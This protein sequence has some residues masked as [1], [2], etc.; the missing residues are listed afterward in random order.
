MEMPLGLPEEESIED[1]YKKG[2]GATPDISQANVQMPQQQTQ[3]E[4][5]AMVKE[6]IDDFRLLVEF[7]RL[8]VEVDTL[9]MKQMENWVMIGKYP[10]ESLPDS[11]FKNELQVRV[12]EAGVLTGKTPL[13]NE[14]K[15]LLIPGLQ[16]LEFLGRHIG[17]VGYLQ[18]YKEGVDQSIAHTKEMEEKLK[19]QEANDT[20]ETK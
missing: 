7:D 5:V 19:E 1:K 11:P 9:I 8:T 12:N 17:A 10:V 4:R 18:S 20:K 13:H 15:Q 3:E 14:E 16:G 2:P 6:K